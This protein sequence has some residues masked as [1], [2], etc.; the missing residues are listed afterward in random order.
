M[1]SQDSNAVLADC[2]DV[3]KRAGIAVLLLVCL[4][5]SRGEPAEQAVRPP[6][7]AL[8]EHFHGSS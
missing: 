7:E 8:Q 1:E 5:D 2:W 4:L 3:C 6:R